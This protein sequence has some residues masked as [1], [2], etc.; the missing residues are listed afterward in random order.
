[1]ACTKYWENV[2][3]AK[4][5]FHFI[6][7]M[8]PKNEFQPFILQLVNLILLYSNR[9][10]ILMIVAGF[11]AFAALSVCPDTAYWFNKCIFKLCEIISLRPARSEIIKSGIN[12]ISCFAHNFENQ[13]IIGY[14]IP[15]LGG[16]LAACR[17]DN[18][19]LIKL[20]KLFKIIGNSREFSYIL[21]IENYMELLIDI[22]KRNNYTKIHTTGISAELNEYIIGIFCSLAERY[23][24]CCHTPKFISIIPT[25][26][27]IATCHNISYK[28]VQ[29]IMKILAYLVKYDTPCS[30]VVYRHIPE[31]LDIMSIKQGHINYTA[32][33]DFLV[34]RSAM[35]QRGIVTTQKLLPFKKIHWVMQIST[36]LSE[37]LSVEAIQ[38]IVANGLKIIH[39]THLNN[40]GRD[41]WQILIPYLDKLLYII[42]PYKEDIDICSFMF[43]IINKFITDRLEDNIIIWRHIA[44]L[45]KHINLLKEMAQHHSLEKRTIK[46]IMSNIIVANTIKKYMLKKRA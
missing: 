29:I 23:R 8:G 1:M 36:F 33:K 25:I 43:L 14:Y 37:D 26:F 30:N 39:C 15:R 2:D 12:M 10:D 3:I 42:R 17:R 19:I 41:G 21:I 22:F 9:G 40:R 18:C 46:I 11:D 35:L 34:Y 27:L 32:R 16:I 7:I 44:L 31:L 38:S 13:R 4:N 5:V 45:T 28:I 20:L 6:K 24:E